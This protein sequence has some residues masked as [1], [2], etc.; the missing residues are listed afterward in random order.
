[1]I[2][3]KLFFLLLVL[4]LSLI[5]LQ[6][7]SGIWLFIDKYGINPSEIYM[8]F[9]GDEERFI[10]TKTFEG[11][12]ETA[13][14]HFM[15]I[16]TIIF[17]YGHFLL[18]TKIISE[19]N[20]QLLIAGLFISSSLDIVSSFFMINGFE[21][22]AWIKIISFWSFEMLMAFLLYTVFALSLRAYRA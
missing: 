15:A 19:K 16:S 14:P 21:I 12:L 3:K 9:A 18:F 10:M 7:I 22:F 1:M 2:S 8:Y 4:A 5:S 6:L 11:L 13:V 20:K 17:V